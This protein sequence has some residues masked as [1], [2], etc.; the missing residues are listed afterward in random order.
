MKRHKNDQLVF[1][2]E[3]MMNLSMAV[4]NGKIDPGLIDLE[5]LAGKSLSNTKKTSIS[6]SHPVRTPDL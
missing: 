3:C 6:S 5:L 1:T 4:L 2:S